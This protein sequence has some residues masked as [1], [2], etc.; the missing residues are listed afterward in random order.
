MNR[1][2]GL[3]WSC[4]PGR[5]RWA[6]LWGLCAALILSALCAPAWASRR[7]AGWM[8]A[9][10]APLHGALVGVP[11]YDDLSLRFADVSLRQ[12]VPLGLPGARV[13]LRI[14]NEFGDGPL[15]IGALH[16]AWRAAAGGSSIRPGSDRA[17]LFGGRPTVEIAAG[18]S[19]YSDPVALAGGAPADLAISLYLPRPTPRASWHL[20]GSRSS[21]RSAPGNHVAMADLPVAVSDRSLYFLAA[22]EV[23]AP[24]DALVWVAFGD[25]ITDGSGQSVDAD[26]NWP[27]RWSRHWRMAGTTAPVAV[28]NAGLSG[29]HLLAPLVG[30]SGIQR[31][32]RDVLDL[33]GVHGLVMLIGINDLA[34]QTRL[35]DLP[36]TVQR[37]IAAQTELARRARAKGI[38]V[39]GATLTPVEGSEY[40]GP[41]MEAARQQFNRWVRAA[42][43]F[44]A[45]VDFDAAVR[46]PA[47]PRRIRASWTGDGLHPNDAGYRAMGDAVVRA[48]ARAG[49]GPP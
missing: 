42:A 16:V 24:A 35:Q 8:P 40:G 1:T 26:A 41:E 46:D 31:F 49:L 38:K 47:D 17:V 27:A 30:P 11:Q 43:V 37:L 14:S 15:Q 22:V 39:V 25:S 34:G 28:L 36:L 33:R 3:H 21:Y 45:I 9:F 20:V 18:A 5:C 12:F 6:L 29:N 4:G 2:R 44:D 7:D 13:R 48:L 10:I 32:D 23:Q 19:L